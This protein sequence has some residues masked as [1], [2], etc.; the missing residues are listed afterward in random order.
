MI[1]RPP[2]KASIEEDGLCDGFKR[3]PMK[4]SIEE[5]G[6]CDGFKRPPMK[7]SIEEDGLCDG[8]KR[9]LHWWH[10][11][12][13]RASS[14]RRIFQSLSYSVLTSGISIRMF[15]YLIINKKK[16]IRRPLLRLVWSLTQ[17]PPKYYIN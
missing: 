15:I 13:M 12:F 17:R 2:M 9:P 8:F 7:V 6:L 1:K 4:A 3:P 5:D 11:P 14:G 10:G 16:W